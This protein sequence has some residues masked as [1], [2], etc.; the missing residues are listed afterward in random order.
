MMRLVSSFFWV[1]TDLR[2]DFP[3]VSRLMLLYFLDCHGTFLCDLVRV[4]IAL[5][6]CFLHFPTVQSSFPLV[7]VSTVDNT[8]A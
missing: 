2:Y 5:A 8:T 3:D 7:I 1:V 6:A 4:E